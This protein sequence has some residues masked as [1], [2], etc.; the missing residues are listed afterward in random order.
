[1]SLVSLQASFTCRL[2]KKITSMFLFPEKSN[3]SL[4]RPPHGARVALLWLVEPHT[5]QWLVDQLTEQ[6]ALL[7]RPHVNLPRAEQNRNLK[8]IS[9]YLRSQVVKGSSLSL[10]P[11]F[12]VLIDRGLGLLRFAFNPSSYGPHTFTHSWTHYTSVTT[13]KHTSVYF[14]NASVR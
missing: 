14:L 5:R 2:D 8:P 12:L 3:L 13:D 1:M 11:P 4:P 9:R 6:L 10:L 7:V